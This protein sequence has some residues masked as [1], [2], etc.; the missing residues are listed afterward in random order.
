[1][2]SLFLR[3]EKPAPDELKG[4]P[5]TER[6]HCSYCDGTEFYRGPSSIGAVNLLCANPECRHWF[7]HTFSG[8]LDDLSRVEPTVDEREEIKK[9]SD[10]QRLD[11]YKSIGAIGAAIYRDG[12]AAVDCLSYDYS[13]ENTYRSAEDRCGGR[14]DNKFVLAGFIQELAN[15]VRAVNRHV[16]EKDENR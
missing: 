16:S 12:G 13:K 15:D 6:L 8:R 5:D 2:L 14:W 4:T 9:R 3:H 7:N 11:F 1:M 10:I